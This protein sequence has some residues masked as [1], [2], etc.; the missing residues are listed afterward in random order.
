MQY[1]LDT[2]FPDLSTQAVRNLF[3][4]FR[5]E[6]DPAKL[7]ELYHELMSNYHH[8]MAHH[9]DVDAANYHQMAIEVYMRRVEQATTGNPA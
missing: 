1:N 2:I 7:D 9:R 5:E 4:R 6:T 8:A 3:K